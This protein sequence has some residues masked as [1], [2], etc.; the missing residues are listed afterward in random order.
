MSMY[1]VIVAKL[2]ATL[3]Y[4]AMRTGGPFCN[5]FSMRMRE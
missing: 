4:T 5:I 3:S 2:Y 1:G